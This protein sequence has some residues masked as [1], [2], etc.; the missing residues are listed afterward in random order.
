[1]AIAIKVSRRVLPSTGDGFVVGTTRPVW[2]GSG[3][4]A[5]NVGC[6][7]GVSRT[8]VASITQVAGATYSDLDITG[9]ITGTVANVTLRNC[10]FTYSYAGDSGGGMLDLQ[11][12]SASGWTIDRCE[13]EPNT[14]GDRYNGIYG[15]DF[16]VIRSVITK[17]VDAIGIYNPNGSGANV[18]VQGCWLGYLAWFNDD[19]YPAR[20]NSHSDG[21]HND[22]TQ[23]G[24][25]VNV[26]YVGNFI[27]GAKFNVANPANCV[28][29]SDCIGYSL[30][31]G[32]GVDVLV[33]APVNTSNKAAGIA[34]MFLAQHSA[35]YHVGNISFTDNW[36]WNLGNNGFY[37]KSNRTASVSPELSAGFSAIT[38]VEFKRNTFGGTARDYGGTYKY[39][40]ARFDTNITVNGY[41]GRGV[42]AYA[43]LDGNVW[44]AAAAVAAP[45]TAIY[46]RY[47]APA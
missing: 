28:L 40:P 6:Y 47:D 9:K 36:L 42:A 17:T 23:H 12:G 24:T 7:P 37:V 3:N 13:F 33:A 1:M 21:S 43:D 35:Y 20:P 4:A 38:D 30:A 16:A 22:G 34:Q 29:D 32:N 26:S 8:T 2:K 44:D 31:T 5:N 15:N 39:Y 27:Q 19:G 25:G 46:L 11:S 10:R 45:G 14:P 18:T 41:T